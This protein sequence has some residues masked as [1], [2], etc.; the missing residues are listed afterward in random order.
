MSFWVVTPYCQHYS[1]F[2]LWRAIIILG[3]VNTKPSEKYEADP[4][5]VL[6]WRLQYRIPNRGKQQQNITDNS[7]WSQ[8]VFQ[9]TLIKWLTVTIL[10]AVYL[11]EKNVGTFLWSI[12]V[13]R[14]C[15]WLMLLE[16]VWHWE[17]SEQIINNLNNTGQSYQTCRGNVKGPRFKNEFTTLVGIVWLC[18]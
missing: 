10:C 2:L 14:E 12:C 4:S 17:L 8:S 6:L 18:S 11:W 7:S 5:S 9:M 1:F 16:V 13:L 3:L 15:S